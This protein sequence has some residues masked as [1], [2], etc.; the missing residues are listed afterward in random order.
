[1][2]LAEV[3]V[4]DHVLALD[5]KHRGKFAK[6]LGIPCSKSVEDFID[7]TIDLTAGTAD[8]IKQLKATP[9]P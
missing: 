2:P 1:M 8:D 3:Q 5:D 9:P 7:I 4:G 6:V